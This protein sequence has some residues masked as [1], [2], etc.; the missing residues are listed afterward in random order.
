M[1]STV[2]RAVLMVGALIGPALA[3]QQM[4]PT[5]DVLPQEKAF[6]MGS[7]A[8]QAS[9]VELHKGGGLGTFHLSDHE[10]YYVEQVTRT[11]T[12]GAEQ[13]AHWADYMM[14]QKGSAKLVMG[15]TLQ[16]PKEARPGELKGDGITGGKVIEL[17]AGDYM[18]IPWGT[19]H[20]FLIAPGG[21][22]HYLLFKVIK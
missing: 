16:N 5:P 7:A 17:E 2:L 1:R 8:L 10:F 20:Q 4:N 11:K 3:Q 12:N 6:H 14:V 19:P 18:M 9:P 13:H 22:F 15:G 21:S